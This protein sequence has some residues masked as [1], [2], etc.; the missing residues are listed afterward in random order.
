MNKLEI[1]KELKDQSGNWT[2]YYYS[3]YPDNSP[4][5]YTG[6]S[7]REVICNLI[8]LPNTTASCEEIVSRFSQKF[9]VPV[10][11]FDG[12]IFEENNLEELCVNLLVD[13]Y[14]N[15]RIDPYLY[16]QWKFMSNGLLPFLFRGRNH[17]EIMKSFRLNYRKALS[18]NCDRTSSSRDLMKK[19]NDAFLSL[20]FGANGIDL[21]EM[22][23]FSFVKTVMLDELKDV[24]QFTINKHKRAF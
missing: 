22:M 1:N 11:V 8:N 23:S 19:L 20:G 12:N 5:L 21:Y 10:N 6:E 15:K 16:Y 4:K 2:F 3:Q 18:E 14:N 24:S 17:E 7:A 13:L 9:F